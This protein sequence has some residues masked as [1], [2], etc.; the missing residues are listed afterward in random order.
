MATL[1]SEVF[2]S[3][4]FKGEFWT[5]TSLASPL[6]RALLDEDV[7]THGLTGPAGTVPAPD[8]VPRLTPNL[9]SNQRVGVRV[10][11]RGRRGVGD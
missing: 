10:R 3:R 5:L 9:T 4:A 8:Y 7:L 2:E 6:V 1:F 11:V